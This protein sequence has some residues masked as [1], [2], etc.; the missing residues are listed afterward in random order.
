MWKCPATVLIVRG[1]Q[2]MVS[3]RGGALH[4]TSR[5]RRASRAL[6]HIGL[7]LEGRKT[8]INAPNPQPKPSPG[9]PWVYIYP[10]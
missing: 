9:R 2:C 6:Q 5:T 3:G 1:P 4:P 10:T 7:A 8:C